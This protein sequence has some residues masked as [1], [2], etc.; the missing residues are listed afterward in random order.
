[1]PDHAEGDNLQKRLSVTG[2]EGAVI[3]SKVHP[4][5]NKLQ[6]P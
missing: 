1:M 4:L 5:P 2:W 6:K 3:R